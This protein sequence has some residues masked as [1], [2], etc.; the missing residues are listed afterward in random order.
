MKAKIEP[1]TEKAKKLAASEAIKHVKDSF[2]IGLGSGSTAAYAIQGIG[3]IVQDKGWQVFGVPTS[4]QAFQLAVE[5]GIPVTSLNENPQLDLSIDGA[6][7]ID[8]MLNMIKGMGG[9]LTKEKIVASASKQNII[10]VDETKLVGELG[11]NCP[12]PVEVLPF[13]ASI[14]MSKIKK[15]RGKPVLREGK[16]KVGPVV[17][18]NGNFIVDAYFGP[19]KL[20]NRLDPQ[21]KMI[22]GV[23]ETGLFIEIADIVY[24]GRST[25]VEKLERR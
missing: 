15:L 16:G 1:W 6:D 19:I 13:A 25:R 17:T 3:K 12:V 22:P 5:C 2:I 8:D 10:I 11:L 9:A 20:P 18:D 23:V 14:V 21:L 7:Q 24:I 4:H